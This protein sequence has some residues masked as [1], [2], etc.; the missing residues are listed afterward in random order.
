MID[1]PFQVDIAEIAKASVPFLIRVL[2]AIAIFFISAKVGRRISNSVEKTLDKV[3]LEQT[4]SAFFSSVIFYIIV[5]LG[6]V[7][8]ASR[9]GFDVS[10]IGA[11][12]AAS[13]LVIGLAVQGSI[14]NVV[15]GFVAI[16]S[17]IYKVGDWLEIHEETGWIVG[18]V[19]KIELLWTVVHTNTGKRI[20]IPNEKVIGN[21]F[22]NHGDYLDEETLQQS[23]A[24]ADLKI[25]KQ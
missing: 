25:L 18:K 13:G 6:T 17:G 16:F 7:F 5:G 8:A 11:L 22:I 10:S 21:I 15:A 23:M 1:L 14:S 9:L 2:I 4:L 24:L 19:A 3:G 12:I 20:I